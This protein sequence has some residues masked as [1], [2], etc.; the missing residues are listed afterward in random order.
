MKAYKGVDLM[1]PTR[2]TPRI[3]HLEEGGEAKPDAV[4]NLCVIF[5]NYV[6]II[7]S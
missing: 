7:M 5:K 6:M 3:F 2:R 1:A 4:C